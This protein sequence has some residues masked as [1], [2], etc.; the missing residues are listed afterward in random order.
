MA[1]LGEHVDGLGFA[2]GK[3]GGAEDGEV[4]SQGGGIAGHVDDA[5]R[6]DLGQGVEH[7]AGAAGPRG[8]EDH[9]IRPQTVLYQPCLLYTSPSP[10]D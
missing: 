5:A 1:R 2:H 4:A 7:L 6:G 8:I 9:D 3:A 10:R